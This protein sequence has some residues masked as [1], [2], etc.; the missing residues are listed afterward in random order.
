MKPVCGSADI[1]SMT[2]RSAKRTLGVRFAV[3]AL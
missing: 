1:F 3:V 2:Y